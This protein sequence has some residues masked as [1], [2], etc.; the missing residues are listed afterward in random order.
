[1]QIV[2][3]ADACSMKKTVLLDM[4]RYV[5]LFAVAMIALGA[6]GQDIKRLGDGTIVVNTTSLGKN[7]KGFGGETPVEIYI[8][9]DEIQ[10]VVALK[11]QETPKYFNR[12]QRLLLP[13][14]IGL[15]VKKAERAKVD[16]VTGATMSSKAVKENIKRGLS[17]Y[18]KNK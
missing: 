7:V 12:V 4:K 6:Q 17:Y 13:Q 1:M 18:K 9:N 10:K 2:E 8:K 15:K 16:G 11:N 14:Y 3:L 5:F